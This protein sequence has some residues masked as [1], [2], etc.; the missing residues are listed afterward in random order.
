[1]PVEIRETIVTPDSSGQV[2]QLQ[3]SDEPLQHES[4]GILV[5]L[6]VCVPHHRTPLLAY[7]QREAMKRAND[8]IHK[9]LQ[10]WAAEIQHKPDNELDPEL[11]PRP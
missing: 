5:Q 8:E 4:P 9:L 3:I 7:L 11:S 6:S 2:V 1:M 10:P